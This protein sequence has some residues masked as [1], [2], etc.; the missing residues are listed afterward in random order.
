[1]NFT[2]SHS[3]EAQ[4]DRNPVHIVRDDRAVGCRVL[5]AEDGIEDSP[6]SPT[7]ELRVAKLQDKISDDKKRSKG[8]DLR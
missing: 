8:G 3:Q 5:P 2:V 6:S 1:M 4:N 7:I